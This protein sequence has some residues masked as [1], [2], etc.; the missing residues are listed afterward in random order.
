MRFPGCINVSPPLPPPVFAITTDAAG[1]KEPLSTG[2]GAKNIRAALDGNSGH[3]LSSQ[4]VLGEGE[5][6]CWELGEPRASMLMEGGWFTHGGITP[7]NLCPAPKMPIGTDVPLLGCLR[8]HTRGVLLGWHLWVCMGALLAAGYQPGSSSS[9]VP[10]LSVGG[11]T[12]RTSDQ[13]R[14]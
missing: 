9:F 14:L 6:L 3:R 10:L 1:R 7:A 12:I 11:E 4:P 8:A 13:G 2:K 5:G